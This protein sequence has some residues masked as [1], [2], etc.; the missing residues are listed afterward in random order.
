MQPWKQH[1]SRWPTE[2][3]IIEYEMRRAA[4]LGKPPG[5]GCERPRHA[6]HEIVDEA[7]GH[8]TREL[9]GPSTRLTGQVLG[10]R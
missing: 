5:A 1:C 9:V 2:R 10:V 4:A 7:T 6:M 8:V 3:E